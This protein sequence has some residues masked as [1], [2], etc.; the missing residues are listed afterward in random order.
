MRMD[1]LAIF[2]LFAVLGMTLPSF[3]QD[4]TMQR[5]QATTTKRV[6]FVS[7]GIVRI[8][9]SYGN[10][11][12]E[13]WDQPDVE[14]TVVKSMP[15]DYK[16]KQPDEAT[17]HLDEVKIVTELKSPTELNISTSLPPRHG[18]VPP[19][20]RTT[21][22]GVS[23]EYEI[24]VPRDS[25]VIIHHGNGYVSVSGI[26]GDIDARAGRGDILLWLRPGSYSID[27]RTKL[28]IVSSELQGAAHNRYLVGESFS[29]VNA[30]PAHRLYLRMGF[31][32]ITIKGIL[33]ES[34]APVSLDKPRLDKP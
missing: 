32:G 6:S 28:G 2:G 14:V 18:W 27:A 8:N 17:K 22:G 15:Y 30:A 10:L 16:P 23:A 13:A 24:H 11:T 19:F 5:A 33:P 25:H 4:V 34:E 12:V 21:T 3:A 1:T 29:Q 7:G 20:S 9:G 26:T 31:G